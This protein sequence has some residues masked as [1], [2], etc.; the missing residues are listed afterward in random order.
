MLLCE[1]FDCLLAG[2]EAPE[3]LEAFGTAKA[4]P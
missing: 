3:L 1:A 4:V 2:A